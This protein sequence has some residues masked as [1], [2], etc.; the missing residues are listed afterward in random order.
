MVTQEGTN[1]NG[2]PRTSACSISTGYYKKLNGNTYYL[3]GGYPYSYQTDSIAFWY[4]YLPS[5]TDTAQMSLNFKK[6]G[7]QFMGFGMPLTSSSSYKYVRFPFNLPQAPDSVVVSFQSSQW[8]DSSL[9]YVGSKLLLDGIHFI[10]DSITAGLHFTSSL[11]GL[12]VYPNPASNNIYIESKEIITT[13]EI[14]D[15]T[16]KKLISRNAF[17]NKG[18]DISILP[19][20]V[21]FIRIITNKEMITRKFI[22]E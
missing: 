3:A 21:Y 16:G 14:I 19:E 2:S 22:K 18:I 15:M 20:G 10:S 9:V 7:N 12:I 1:Q 6:D 8:K 5:S 4:K 11:N 17:N 13:A